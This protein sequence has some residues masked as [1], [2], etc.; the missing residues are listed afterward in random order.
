MA[1]ASDIKP[2]IETL[3][4]RL[5]LELYDLVIG[6]AGRRSAVRVFIDKPGGVTVADCENASKEIAMLL[7]VEEFSATPYTLEVSSPGLD[8]PLKNEK[9]FRRVV[10]E[11]VIL[12]VKDSSGGRKT[13]AGK[14]VE[15][16]A[17]VVTL[18]CPEETRTIPLDAIAGGKVE[19]TF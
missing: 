4:L 13:V 6:H 3:L 15:C 16:S 18:Q 7:D 1:T 9:D 8:R 5:G 2:Q 19:I 14:I 17:G 12:Q 10:G 11:K